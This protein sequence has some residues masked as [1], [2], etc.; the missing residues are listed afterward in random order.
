MLLRS[1]DFERV[2]F[3]PWDHQEFYLMHIWALHMKCIKLEN[4]GETNV[5]KKEFLLL[6][7]SIDEWEWK[8][9]EFPWDKSNGIGVLVTQLWEFKGGNCGL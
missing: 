2:L 9:H 1:S 6:K 4:V 3:F 8:V 5:R 7:T